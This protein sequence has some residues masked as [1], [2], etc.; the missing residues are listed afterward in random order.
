MVGAPAKLDKQQAQQLFLAG[1]TVAAIAAD[2]GVSKRR[3]QQAVQNVR[4]DHPGQAMPTPDDATLDAMVMQQRMQLGPNYGRGMMAGALRAAHPGYAFGEHRVNETLARLFPDEHEARKSWAQMKLERGHYHAPYFGYSVHLDLDCK[5]QE[6]GLYIGAIVDGCSRC[7]CTLTALTDKLPI[8]IYTALWMV[9]VAAHGF[10]DQLITDHGTEWL[11]VAFICHFMR[12]TFGMNGRAAHSAVP[13][14][15][16]IRVEKFNFEI[17]VRVLIPI[18]TLLNEMEAAGI[19][20]KHNH[21]QVGAFSSLMQPLMQVGLDRL[22]GAWNEHY[23]RSIRDRPG[24]GGKPNDRAARFPHPGGQLTFPPGFDGVAEYEQQ[25]GPLRREREAAPT[26]DR[27]YGQP[28]AQQHRDAAV[29]A[30]FG[31]ATAAQVWDEILAENYVRFLT[32]YAVYVSM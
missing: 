20:D 13:S 10:P 6:Y 14:T 26:L 22:R 29:G 18:R 25:Y 27:W 24:T 28:A 7:V 8:T 12:Y 9:F 5:L 21:I 30:A 11:V 1:M 32:A 4:T 3:V 19:M 16:N 31:G 15:R 17:N 23:V 2:V